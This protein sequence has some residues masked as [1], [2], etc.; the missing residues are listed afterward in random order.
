VN[1]DLSDL[2]ENYTT[3]NGFVL[4]ELGEKPGVGTRLETRCLHFEVLE[5]DNLVVGK[6]RI[7]RP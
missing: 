6:T 4:H 7:S 3:I 5:V 1:D 2:D